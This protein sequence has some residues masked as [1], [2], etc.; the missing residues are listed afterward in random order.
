MRILIV[1]DEAAAVARMRKMLVEIDPTVTVV[2]DVPTVKEAVEWIKG[3]P[4]PD[5][6]F[7][8]VQLADGESFAIFKAVEV[9]FPVVFATAFDAYALQAFRV[10]AVDYLLKPLKKVDLAQ[11]LLRAQKS[12]VVRDHSA[13]ANGPQGSTPP[14]V[15]VKRFLIRYG[16]HFKLVEPAQIAY[17]HSLQKNTFLRTR[18]GRDLPLEESLDRLEKQL[19]PARFI[20]LNRQLIV[21]LRSIK[22]LLAY[23]KSRVKVVLDPPYGEDAIV[24]SER[25]AEFKRWLAGE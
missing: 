25:S 20:R 10:N 15:P 8:D 7:F 17:I 12:G 4:A 9:A 1:E 18:E 23:S 24:S 21:E 5:L 19:D 14:A 6:A 13:L 16:D 11:A 22:E 3:N 2:A